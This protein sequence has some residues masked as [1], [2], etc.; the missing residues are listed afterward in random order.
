MG[1]AHCA[2]A[3]DGP[4]CADPPDATTGLPTTARS[5]ARSG[6]KT[7][8]SPGIGMRN[9]STSPGSTHGGLARSWS[10]CVVSGRHH[11]VLFDGACSVLTKWGSGR[12]AERWA[13]GIW[14]Q[15]LGTDRVIWQSSWLETEST[16]LL[17]LHARLVRTWTVCN[18]ICRCDFLLADI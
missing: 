8:A 7:C 4:P 15:G 13:A 5:L 2:N 11:D 17:T 6:S 1:R 18:T 10:P 9:R 16:S 14:P 3:W 12:A